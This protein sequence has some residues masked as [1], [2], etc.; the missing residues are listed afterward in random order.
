M[1]FFAQ[2]GSATASGGGMIG[3]SKLSDGVLLTFREGSIDSQN[4][5]CRL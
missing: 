3:P 2:K 5:P 4:G 1:L